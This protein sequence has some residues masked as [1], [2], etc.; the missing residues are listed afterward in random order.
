MLRLSNDARP[1]GSIAARTF[2]VTER[3]SDRSF[4]IARLHAQ[5]EVHDHPATIAVNDQPSAARARRLPVARSLPRCRWVGF[6]DSSHERA[7]RQMPGTSR[8]LTRAIVGVSGKI[9]LQHPVL[10]YGA[11]HQQGERDWGNECRNPCAERN[12]TGDCGEQA[13]HPSGRNSVSIFC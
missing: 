2:H 12:A 11:P 13:R 5:I 7:V 8:Y 4:G 9:M 6:R 1:T 3:N 10:N